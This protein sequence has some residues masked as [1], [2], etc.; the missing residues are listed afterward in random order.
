VPG[1]PERQVIT[2][3]GTNFINIENLSLSGA[4]TGIAINYTFGVLVSNC[5]ITDNSFSGVLA[6]TASGSL[7]VVDTVITSSG[8][9]S[10]RA[11]W[12]TNGSNI[13]CT[14]CEID[15]H[16]TG[17]LLTQGS[18]ANIVGS[19]VLATRI[20]VDVNGGSRFQSFSAT[21]TIEGGSGP[22]HAA[23]QLTDNAS[24]SL[25]SGDNINGSIRLA[26]K[27]VAKLWGASQSNPSFF[28]SVESGSSLMTRG[29][30]SLEGDIDISE[31]SNVTLPSGSTTTGS[32]FCS[33]GGDAVCD[34][35]L[36][37]TSTSNCGQCPNP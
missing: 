13:T 7:N 25:F 22:S 16:R 6:G 11:I 33:L 27:S 35:P 37:A 18:Q 17:I 34:T 30:T 21:S 26:G 19:M 9:P 1:G 31:F 3:V 32:L 23:I 36:T 10:N 15:N 24:A 20:G 5:I 8:A 2:L 29:S 28:N 4:F 12:A 14:R